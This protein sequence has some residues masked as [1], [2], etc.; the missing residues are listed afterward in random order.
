MCFEGINPA[1]PTLSFIVNLTYQVTPIIMYLV[2]FSVATLAEFLHLDILKEYSTEQGKCVWQIGTF[3]IIEGIPQI[4]FLNFSQSWLH[5]EM[6]INEVGKNLVMLKPQTYDFMLKISQPEG[7]KDK[8]KS[9]QLKINTHDKIY[10]YFIQE[11]ERSFK[12]PNR[13]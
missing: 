11:W 1:I 8:S 2:Y 13:C 4:P 6:M 5:D 3:L 9:C 7:E 10:K 12:P